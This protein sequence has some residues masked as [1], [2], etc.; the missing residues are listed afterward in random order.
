[1]NVQII[2]GLKLML[3]WEYFDRI[4]TSIV[5]NWMLI[6]LFIRAAL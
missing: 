6:D 4:S 1:M 3:K 2:A 5:Q